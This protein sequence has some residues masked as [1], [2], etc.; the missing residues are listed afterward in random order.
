M[1][2]AKLKCRNNKNKL[3][4]IDRKINGWELTQKRN[5]LGQ[6][7][8]QD[9]KLPGGNK[10]LGQVLTGW[11][12]GCLG[13][14]LTQIKTCTIIVYS[15]VTMMIFSNSTVL[16]KNSCIVATCQSVCFNSIRLLLRYIFRFSV[17][18][19]SDC[20]YVIFSVFL[21]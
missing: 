15:F 17:L 9:R 8:T 13:I 11:Q 1:W 7:I 20:C 21:F 16:N 3:K 19:P 2:V 14:D 18:I 10:H 5:Y 12:D 4:N 6:E